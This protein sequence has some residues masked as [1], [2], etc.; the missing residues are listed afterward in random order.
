MGIDCTVKPHFHFI[1]T[2]HLDSGLIENELDYVL[3]G[4]YDGGVYPNPDE[5][6]DYKWIDWNEFVTDISANP[7]RYTAWLQ[8]LV[9]DYKQNIEE[10]LFS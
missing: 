4:T 2:A 9:T 8:I 5:V 6:M 3:F 7:E 1:Y 10:I